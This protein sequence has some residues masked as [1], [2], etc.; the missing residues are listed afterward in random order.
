MPRRTNN[1]GLVVSPVVI[2]LGLLSAVMVI[3]LVVAIVLGTEETPSTPNTPSTPSNSTTPNTPNT[4]STP[5]LAL[6]DP[7]RES[8][9]Y[10]GPP[11]TPPKES[12]GVTD[13]VF[14]NFVF[15]RRTLQD[16]KKAWDGPG[17][18][19]NIGGVTKTLK[20]WG[21]KYA[22][23]AVNSD[24]MYG[25]N[26]PT[27]S[28]YWVWISWGKTLPPKDMLDTGAG[29]SYGGKPES[30]TQYK[31]G[32]KN[33]TF[34]DTNRTPGDNWE[35]STNVIYDIS[36]VVPNEVSTSVQNFKSVPGWYEQY[37][38]SIVFDTNS[39]NNPHVDYTLNE[40]GI[41]A[42][43]R[44]ADI[45]TLRTAKH[46]LEGFRNTCI[47]FNSTPD[48]VKFT[49]TLLNTDSHFTACADPS[50]TWPNCK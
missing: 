49:G 3:V 31:V 10:K 28:N 26:P 29:C 9:C 18:T 4:P 33:G 41:E 7:N 45:F 8:W 13:Y 22:A 48:I 20:E 24:V 21:Y 50:K 1:F 19:Y 6:D 5:T 39:E 17:L 37:H 47:G 46:S 2:G 40:C 14:I 16:I 43:K 36:K 15:P 44:G 30:S 32:R 42:K 23:M 25:T 11:N 35:G 38:T 27:E 12:D 34:A